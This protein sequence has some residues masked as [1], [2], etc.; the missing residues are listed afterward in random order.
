MPFPEPT[1]SNWKQPHTYMKGVCVWPGLELGT[2]PQANY[3]PLGKVE[4]PT[5]FIGC[6]WFTGRREIGNRISFVLHFDT[7]PLSTPAFSVTPVKCLYNPFAKIKLLLA[8]NSGS[9][10]ST[11]KTI[12]PTRSSDKLPNGRQ[13]TKQFAFL[14]MPS[15][16]AKIQLRKLGKKFIEK[17]KWVISLL[18]WRT[19]ISQ[20]WGTADQAKDN[21]TKR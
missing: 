21:N 12:H 17:T 9:F 5:D 20:Y 4:Y 8:G 3:V 11:C 14:L 15:Q 2:I 13:W 1:N 7:Y 10:L 18:P 16:T 19:L 6:F